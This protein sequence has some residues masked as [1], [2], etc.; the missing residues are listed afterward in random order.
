MPF[1][2]QCVAPRE[3]GAKLDKG[4]SSQHTA[5]VLFSSLQIPEMVRTVLP[6]ETEVLEDAGF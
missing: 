6:G 2:L 3:T 1:G 4:A 5:L